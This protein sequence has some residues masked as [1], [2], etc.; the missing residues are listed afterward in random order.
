MDR[1]FAGFGAKQLTIC[2]LYIRNQW[3]NWK[4]AADSEVNVT[5]LRLWSWVFPTAAGIHLHLWPA[6]PPIVLLDDMILKLLVLNNWHLESNVQFITEK[7]NQ[8][9]HETHSQW[10]HFYNHGGV[11]SKLWKCNYCYLSS[12][13]TTRWPLS[14]TSYKNFFQ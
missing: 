9:S 11:K 4:D 5:L 1:L 13:L 14:F 3:T 6:F 2:I 10:K 12:N 8:R 7:H